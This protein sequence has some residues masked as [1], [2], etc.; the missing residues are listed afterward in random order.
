MFRFIGLISCCG[1]A[2]ATLWLAN[3]TRAEEDFSEAN[4][5]AEAPSASTAKPAAEPNPFAAD[6]AM[7]PSPPPSKPRPARMCPVAGLMTG[8]DRLAWLHVRET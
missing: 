6:S 1:L 7:T 4:P 8:C 5:F 3:L 2:A